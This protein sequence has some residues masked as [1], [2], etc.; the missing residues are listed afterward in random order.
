MMSKPI[1]TQIVQVVQKQFET[2]SQI[3]ADDLDEL[4]RTGETNLIE[5][6]PFKEDLEMPALEGG[7][8][9]RFVGNKRVGDF[10]S[11]VLLPNTI[12]TRKLWTE[13]QTKIA[14]KAGLTGNQITL[15]INS[16]NWLKHILLPTLA[17]II[18]DPKKAEWFKS[19]DVNFTGDDYFRWSSR[20]GIELK[21][22][23]YRRRYLVS[24]FNEVY[25]GIIPE[26][27]KKKEKETEEKDEVAET[28]TT[29]FLFA[30]DADADKLLDLLKC[31]LNKLANGQLDAVTV[32]GL[33]CDEIRFEK[34]F[35]DVVRECGHIKLSYFPL[36]REGG[37]VERW[38]RISL[39]ETN[40]NADVQLINVD[41]VTGSAL[42]ENADVA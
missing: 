7:W 28:S 10:G 15:W 29:G 8:M 37:S 26:R 19:F 5:N 42:Q 36:T 13:G 1:K 22:S 2:L 31:D 30:Q 33:P 35:T 14:T 3:S 34:G 25:L 20:S 6:F 23:K 39:N 18:S 12:W 17:E 24:L 4:G 40:D 11:I 21:C 38:I 9:C 27:S 32:S 16:S 41:L